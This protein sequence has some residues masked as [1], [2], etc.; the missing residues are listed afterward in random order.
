M[1]GDKSATSEEDR[2]AV[3]A[4]VCAYFEESGYSIIGEQIRYMTFDIIRGG[5]GF[6]MGGGAQSFLKKNALALAPRVPHM[7]P[8]ST[9]PT[10]ITRARWRTYFRLSGRCGRWKW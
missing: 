9:R 4:K 6:L 3:E 7:H 2:N 8:Q 1:T 10:A 5:V